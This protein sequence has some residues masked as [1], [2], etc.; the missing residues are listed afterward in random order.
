MTFAEKMLQGL[1]LMVEIPVSH[2]IFKFLQHCLT[3]GKSRKRIC[4]DE[5]WK[6]SALH[7]L[8]SFSIDCF[9]RGRQPESYTCITRCV[10][11]FIQHLPLSITI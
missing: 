10:I 5:L 4:S 3:L 7:S 8:S 2:N 9:S 1:L 6:T 11:L